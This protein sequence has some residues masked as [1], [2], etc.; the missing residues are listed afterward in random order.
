[1]K[2]TNELASEVDRHAKTMK[3][4]I[5]E[6]MVCILSLPDNHRIRRFHGNPHAFVMSFKD[7]GDNYSPEHHDFKKQYELVVAELDKVQP[8]NIMRR[9]LTIIGEGKIQVGSSRTYCVNLHPDVLGHLKKVAGVSRVRWTSNAE[10][11]KGTC[12]G[13]QSIDFHDKRAQAQA[14]CKRL[15]AEGFGGDRQV[16]PVRTWT[17]PQGVHEG[18]TA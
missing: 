17:E 10:W 9:P 1:M 7:L 16:F 2:T 15:E 12:P 4:I 6:L 13:D 14:I 3:G 5:D 18:D 11:P 8:Y